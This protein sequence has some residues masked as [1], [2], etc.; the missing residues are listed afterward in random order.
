M[1]DNSDAHTSRNLLSEHP[2]IVIVS[3]IA[4]TIAIFIFAT[5]IV[6]LPSIFS[7]EAKLQRQL[8]G[9]WQESSGGTLTFYENGVFEEQ[10]GLIPLTGFYNVTDGSH[11]T[12]QASGLFGIAGSQ[13]WEV[14]ISGNTLFIVN[15]WDGSS[16]SVTQ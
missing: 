6:D 14:N 5:G 13:V 11:I 16:I 10:G 7:P 2:V 3:V 12:I 4:A 9:R 15:T 1:A 8:I